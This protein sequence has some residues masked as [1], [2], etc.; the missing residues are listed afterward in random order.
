MDNLITFL[1]VETPNRHN[2]S[3]CSIAMVQEDV[4]GHEVSRAHTLVNPMERFDDINMRIHGITPIDVRD[5]PTF[6]E[7]WEDVISPCIG[8]S[9]VVAHNAAFDL[10]VLWKATAASGKPIPS[11]RYACTKEMARSLIPDAR[12][13]RLPDVCDVLGVPM[14]KHHDAI[15]DTDGC[16]GVF[17]K[18][19]Q[20]ADWD[21]RSFIS[22][23]DGPGSRNRGPSHPAR[24]MRTPSAKTMEMRELIEMIEGVVSD[25]EVMTDEAMNL[26]SWMAVHDNLLHDPIA[27][28]IMDDLQEALMDGNV[29]LLESNDLIA[30]LGRLIDPT[31]PDQPTVVFEGRRFCLTGTFEHGTK[32]S[33]ADHIRELGGEVDKNVTKKCDYV[34]IGGCGNESYSYGNYGGKVKKAMEWQENGVPIEVIRE[35]DIYP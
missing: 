34:V 15:A 17:W 26:L 16:M 35:C 1:D 6:D 19:A 24:K 30:E 14:G 31:G 18:L 5:A 29:S 12:S 9:L 21:L 23:Y 25:G 33:V 32:E 20:I 22:V 13:F 4:Q 8:R 27:T 3:I 2:D 10:C 28:R 11:V 7:A